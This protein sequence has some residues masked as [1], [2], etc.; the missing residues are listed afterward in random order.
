MILRN[1]PEVTIQTVTINRQPAGGGQSDKINAFIDTSFVQ[2]VD[3]IEQMNEDLRHYNVRIV[4]TYKKDRANQL[5]YLTARQ[6]EYLLS[7]M[8]YPDFSAITSADNYVR[9]LRRSLGEFLPIQ[10]DV[11]PAILTYVTNNPSSPFSTINPGHIN[12]GTI[13]S[14]EDFNLSPD[15]VIWDKQLVSILPRDSDGNIIS[16]SIASTTIGRSSRPEGDGPQ[17]DRVI[18]NV[19]YGDAQEE[20]EFIGIQNRAARHNLSRVIIPRAQMDL[21]ESL[22]LAPD[23]DIEQLTIYAFIYRVPPEFLGRQQQEVAM[24]LY[25]GTSL[26]TSATVFGEKRF[27]P[28]F[29]LRSAYLNRQSLY[30]PSATSVD[31]YLSTSTLQ[32]APDIYTLQ[33]IDYE[34]LSERAARTESIFDKIYRNFMP[35]YFDKNPIL[36]KS[37]GV[38]NSFTEAW[39]SKDSEENLRI[40]F[41]IDLVAYLA[42][43]SYF[44]FVYENTSLAE[45][46]INGTGLMSGSSPS[47]ISNVKVK[48]QLYKKEGQI[49]NNSLGTIGKDFKENSAILYPEV[50]LDKV[51]KVHISLEGSSPDIENKFSFYETKDTLANYTNQITQGTIGYACDATVIDSAPLLIRNVVSILTEE[52]NKIRQVFEN[53]VNSVPRI[54]EP[55]LGPIRDGRG[56][57]DPVQRLLAVP[58]GQI[59]DQ[60]RTSYRD[61]ILIAADVTQWVLDE[62]VPATQSG[63]TQLAAAMTQ[64]LDVNGGIIDPEKILELEKL[65]SFTVM[66]FMK[67]L[68]QIWP[69]QPLGNT[70]Y[71]TTDA[72]IQSRPADDRHF[73]IYKLSHSFGEKYYLGKNKQLGCDYMM[74]DEPNPD[75]I[76]RLPVPSYEERIRKEFNKYYTTEPGQRTP[77]PYVGTY[78]ASSFKYFTPH[79]LRVPT[80]APQSEIFQ[81]NLANFLLNSPQSF[82]DLNVYAQAFSDIIQLNI[83]GKYLNIKNPRIYHDLNVTSNQSLY[84]SLKQ[85]LWQEYSTQ[86]LETTSKQF[87]EPRESSGETPVTTRGGYSPNTIHFTGPQVIPTIV[88]GANSLR[89]TNAYTY[90]QQADAQYIISPGAAAGTGSGAKVPGTKQP[91]PS[92]PIKLPFAIFGEM[93]I[94]P[95]MTEATIY[96]KEQFNSMTSLSNISATPETIVNTVQSSLSAIPNQTK[97][98]MV[99]AM[100]DEQ[101]ELGDPLDARIPNFNARRP[102][103][104]DQDSAEFRDEMISYYKP[105]QNIPPFEKTADP[106]KVY[107][108]F[109]AFWMNY[110]NIFIVEYLSGFGDLNYKSGI[111]DTEAQRVGID[112]RLD[113]PDSQFLDKAKMPI[114][115]PITQE[116]A[117]VI[118]QSENKNLFCRVRRLSPEDMFP[119]LASLGDDRAAIASQFF[120][121]ERHFNL[122]TYNKYFFLSN[123]GA[124]KKDPQPTDD[125]DPTGDT[126][127][128][129]IGGG[130]VGT[131]GTDSEP[132]EGEPVGFN[133]GGLVGTISSQTPIY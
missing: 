91:Q 73:P 92:I 51:E 28:P 20:I 102:T 117:T 111:A 46:L 63:E 68:T 55:P 85:T 3:N 97:S 62:F 110:K 2:T 14:R 133:L 106:M 84:D 25:T 79:V 49:G 56:L 120:N 34:E 66:F 35:L 60:H 15:T 127:G 13:Y 72:M 77:S 78:A 37:I 45:A 38:D 124:I 57:W 89:G 31:S 39:F 7:E 75:G 40:C 67:K 32:M 71:G 104:Y 44:P 103:L 96:Q 21:T 121:S 58:I 113:E 86:I 33:Y 80:N 43:T 17:T 107:A 30:P 126:P 50:F 108:K 4:A 74:E 99:V 41:G 129:V 48:R 87:E 115:T 131:S 10:P 69:N 114:W 65:I 132:E 24:G 5:D 11:N 61:I 18:S 125:P 123:Q 128:G 116:I 12:S 90:L 23:D 118:S 59:E 95:S 36:K 9:A 109:M 16:R 22:N 1:I 112:R 122:E 47:S 70:N 6:N 54:G 52:Q 27:W 76:T 8:L 119:A 82:Y 88:G 98:L 83:E 94:N 26:I 29:G 81:N 101:L 93:S 105:G 19:D 100:S 130:M 53:I 42:A 64:I